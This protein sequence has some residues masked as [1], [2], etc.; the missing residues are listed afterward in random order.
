VRILDGLDGNFEWGVNEVAC[1]CSMPGV[2]ALVYYTP[3]I[4]SIMFRYFYILP[5]TDFLKTVI[6]TIFIF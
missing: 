3:Y 5:K 1:V 2:T 4:T 6:I